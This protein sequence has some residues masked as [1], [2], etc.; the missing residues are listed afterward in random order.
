MAMVKRFL[1]RV[2]LRKDS[3]MSLR[4]WFAS[5][6]QTNQVAAWGAEIAQNAQADVAARL[7]Y[8]VQQMS[9][10]EA[11]GYIRAR[12]AAVLDDE[13][14]IL[15]QHAFCSP[16]LKQAIRQWASDEIVRMTIGDLLKTGRPAV[17]VLR[18]AA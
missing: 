11:R 5:A 6:R 12:L 9:L 16:S 3:P 8:A 13:M 15:T 7:G 10:P 17:Q 4:S 1:S 18:R 2:N 14:E